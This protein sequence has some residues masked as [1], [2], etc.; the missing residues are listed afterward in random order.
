MSGPINLPQ[1]FPSNNLSDETKNCAIVHVGCSDFL[2][3][4]QPF[5]GEISRPTSHPPPISSNMVLISSKKYACETCIKGHRSS[6][7]NHADR[8]LYEIKKKGRPVTQ[9]EHCRELRKTKQVHV[10]CMCE[11]KDDTPQ[12]PQQPRPKKCNTKVPDSAAF[13]HGLPQALEA[14]QAREGISSDSDHGGA[15]DS[16]MCK[17]GGSCHCCTPRKSAPRKRKGDPSHQ[18][19]INSDDSAPEH[20]PGSTPPGMH[21]VAS[22]SRTSSQI[23]A[24]IAEL[25]PVLPR[26]PSRDHPVGPVHNPSLNTPHSRTNRHQVPDNMYFSPYGRAYGLSHDHTFD[27]EDRHV[28]SNTQAAINIPAFPIGAQSPW[29]PSNG[30]PMLESRFPS[31]CGCG[32]GCRCPGCPQHSG[33]DAIPPAS[34]Y[35]TCANP[36]ACATCLDCTILS[37]PVSAPPDTALSIYDAHQTDSIDEWLRQVS[38]PPTGDNLSQA[39]LQFPP[40]TYSDM[41]SLTMSSASPARSDGSC[42]HCPP[43]FCECSDHSGYDTRASSMTT[44]ATSGER[45]S[46]CTKQTPGHY[47]QRPP[48]SHV[49]KPARSPL[50]QS[51]YVDLGHMSLPDISRTRSASSQSS[52][53]RSLNLASS[54]PVDSLQ[55]SM[56]NMR[57][58]HSSPELDPRCLTSRNPVSASAFQNPT[59]ASSNPDSENSVDDVQ[60]HYDPSLDGMRLY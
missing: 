12:I 3:Q 54:S 34:A 25:R 31:L 40:Q 11:N 41:P 37:L 22:S 24:R 16:C 5:V 29:V 36:G 10:K 48:L 23:L 32:D 51:S 44:F 15:G 45:A 39:Q 47:H 18:K 30:E 33:L 17:Y 49:P 43:G 1:Y 6:T 59:Y 50:G 53:A 21:H 35:S 7:C 57:R 38:L 26:P 8:P 52:S 28:A 4:F 42:G 46:C 9:C 2:T 19:H 56:Y 58:G 60:S 13:P 27:N 14:S 55:G 20:I